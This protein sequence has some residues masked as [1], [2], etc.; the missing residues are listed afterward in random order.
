MWRLVLVL[1][2]ALF[3]SVAANVWPALDAD[4]VRRAVDHA[5]TVAIAAVQ[6]ERA[7]VAAEAAGALV[8]GTLRTSAELAVRDGAIGAGQT[9]GWSV[10]VRAVTLSTDWN[11]VPYGPAYEAA[12]RAG[13]AYEVAH[14]ALAEAR[15]QAALDVI[16]ALASIGRATWRLEI[17]EVRMASMERELDAVIQQAEA[18]TLS[19]MHVADARLRVA[20]TEAALAVAQR[21]VEVAIAALQRTFGSTPDELWTHP[22]SSLAAMSEQVRGLTPASPLA[23]EPATMVA[24][25]AR[26]ARVA[27]AARAVDDAATGQA[28]AEREAGVSVSVTARAYSVGE[29]GR[30]SLGVGWDTRSYQPSAELS[31]DPSASGAT[32][33]G[34]TMSLTVSLPIGPAVGDAVTAAALDQA[35]AI[36]R[37]E[38]AVATADVALDAALASHDDALRELALAV[39]RLALRSTQLASL[40]LR[41]AAG[42][43]APLDLERAELDH[44]EQA[45]AVLRMAD[46]VW[47]ARA[48]LEARVGQALSCDS[49]AT[50]VAAVV[51]EVP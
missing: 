12:E 29:A 49:I 5:P 27:E 38:Q 25:V 14:A 2:V 6:L 8:T 46:Q 44:L 35:L 18:G 36:E 21:E 24:A 22:L 20:Q 31:L 3:G 50:A 28:R 9:E 48:R 37:W 51:S 32:Q 17:E 11:L 23:V 34:A 45:L 19:S 16:E 39:E 30:A 47:I 7:R 15:L 43:V 42:A 10:D 13:R 33:V 40:R 1:L 26:D 41:A 4:A